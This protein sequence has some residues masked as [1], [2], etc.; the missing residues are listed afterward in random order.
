MADMMEKIAMGGLSMR[1]EIDLQIT[2]PLTG[3]PYYKFQDHNMVLDGLYAYLKMLC[4][5]ALCSYGGWYGHRPMTC[6]GASNQSSNPMMDLSGFA[7][8]L[9]NYTSTGNDTFPP[10]TSKS[11]VLKCP[12]ERVVLTDGVEPENSGR[13]GICGNIVAEADFRTAVS[14]GGTQGTFT[15]AKSL[16]DM[17]RIYR[18]W[19]WTSANGNGTIGRIQL[20]SLSN[21]F[22]MFDTTKSLS[23]LKSPK[24]SGTFIGS[25]ENRL[26]F[27]QTLTSDMITIRACEI[28]VDTG[29]FTEQETSIVPS[30]FGVTTEVIVSSL[31][32]DKGP[33]KTVYIVGNASS[34]KYLHVYTYDIE[35]NTLSV[36]QLYDYSLSFY[37]LVWMYCGEDGNL[38]L[39]SNGN[40]KPCLLSISPTEKTAKQL[41]HSLEPLSFL[42][43]AGINEFDGR[44]LTWIN[45]STKIVIDT[46]TNKYWQKSY[47]HFKNFDGNRFAMKVNGVIYIVSIYSSSTIPYMQIDCIPD[48]DNLICAMTDRLLPEPV[49]KD[50]MPM[51]VG[52]TLE[53]E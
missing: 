34:G 2:N 47:S 43:I 12:V 28:D 42:G 46:T 27:F 39:F 50:S 38:T 29:A 21:P 6:L 49:V 11:A 19:D 44:Y 10:S 33:G 14:S 5:A 23:M 41:P 13:Y 32:M 9:N 48:F 30:D 20:C 8:G 31:L 40:N 45:A 1:G 4:I 18:R 26:L 52:Y 53:F 25:Y 22:P 16:E 17:R 7:I 15:Y 24:T 3:R 37:R 35:N 36:F 51:Y